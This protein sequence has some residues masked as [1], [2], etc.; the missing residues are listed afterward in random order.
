[1]KKILCAILAILCLLIPVSAKEKFHTAMDLY[2][3]WEGIYPDYVCGVW[4][5]AGGGHLTI[6]VVDEDAKAKILGQVEDVSTMTLILQEHSQAQLLA[7]Q[8]AMM[9]YFKKGWIWST[10]LDERNNRV[11]IGLNLDNR[12]P[13]MDAFVTDMAVQYGTAVAF[14]KG[15]PV[16]F[17]VGEVGKVDNLCMST[18][19]PWWLVGV[20]FVF[21]LACLCVMLWHRRRVWMTT[22]GTA[23]TD[24][25][26]AEQINQTPLGPDE[27]LEQRI[28]ESVR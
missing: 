13:E 3:S 1:M 14:E 21:V 5:T 9:P 22:A 27:D 4:S 28:Y 6:A 11:V 8:D 25:S 17:T 10:S 20:V 12:S 2:Q 24:G 16:E 18:E 15:F 23:V 26:V 7:I 19:Q